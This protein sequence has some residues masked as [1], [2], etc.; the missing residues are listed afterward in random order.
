MSP[1]LRSLVALSALCMTAAPLACS[2]S[3]A[4]EGDSSEDELRHKKDAGAKDSGAKDSGSKDAGKPDATSSDAAPPFDAGPG[5]ALP[6]CDGSE[7]V[8]YGPMATPVDG[9]R[10]GTYELGPLML[11]ADHAHVFLE[12]TG[13]WMDAQ[14]GAARTQLLPASLAGGTELAAYR[15]LSG[16]TGVAFIVGSKVMAAVYDGTTFGAPL[17]TPC[18]TLGSLA[19]DVRVAADG[20]LWVR[21]GSNF[22]EQGASGLENRGGGPVGPSQ[23]D[24]TAAGD[25]V[26]LG[27]GD[28]Q[29]GELL[30]VWRLVRGAGGWS[31][32]GALLPSDVAAVAPSIE[33]GF[34]L[35]SN[36]LGS[37]GALAS[38]GSIHL[39]SDARCIGQG[40]R[41]KTQVYLRSRDGHAW[42]A[43]TL[44]DAGSLTDAQVTWRNTAFWAG[45]YDTVRYVSMSSPKPTFDGSTWSYPDRQYNVIA[46][47]RADDGSVSFARI[48]RSALPGWTERGFS[49][50]SETGQA[51]LLTRSGLT[52]AL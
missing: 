26:I 41:N 20:H 17:E 47:C 19:C 50:F 52:Q 18:T 23:W 29:A 36:E 28:T 15:S 27:P 46:R 24:V 43:V 5:G 44:P 40:D 13:M 48:A 51:T 25:V 7:T 10:Y 21:A 45:D 32:T 49:G 42:D 16:R 35:G 31:K 14:R 37:V 30:A 8:I 11:G 34:R 39:F 1:H 4:P 22:Y 33:G 9:T 12:G 38:D 6:A 3:S 2:G